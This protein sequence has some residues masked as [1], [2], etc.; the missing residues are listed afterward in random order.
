MEVSAT[1]SPF[2]SAEAEDDPFAGSDFGDFG[3]DEPAAV[4]VTDI[5]PTE[6]LGDGR[7]TQEESPEPAAPAADIP[8]VNAEGEIVDP[9]TSTAGAATA[10]AN[11]P[12]SSPPAPSAPAASTPNPDLGKTIGEVEA[13]REMAAAEAEEATVDLPQEDPPIA[14]TA[15]AEIV[16]PVAPKPAAPAAPASTTVS[17][18]DPAVAVAEMPEDEAP[19]PAEKVDKKKRVTHR[20]YTVL[21]VIGPDDF[22]RVSWYEKDGK[23]APRGDGAK[24]QKVALA[25]DAEGA[26]AIGYAAL[27]SP[28]KGAALVAVAHSLFQVKEVKPAEP[29]P[30]KRRLKI[31]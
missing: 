16:Q 20:R 24:R 19:I 22:R 13:E 23:M 17:E 1:D 4:A 30:A 15:G 10:G 18:P 29:E 5:Q 27:G 11:V 12:Q 6:P 7:P 21:Q 25:R 2:D 9:P 26:L 14:P 31:S 8:V 28:E 3:E